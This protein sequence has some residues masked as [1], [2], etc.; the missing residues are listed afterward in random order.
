MTVRARLAVLTPVLAILLSSAVGC[1]TVGGAFGF[2]PPAYKLTEET[3]MLRAASPAPAPLPR[4]LSKAL[5]PAYIVEP[6]DTLLVL[7]ARLDSPLR[8]PGDQPVMPDGTIDLGEFGRPVVAG[9]TVAQIE[10]EVRQLVT[11]RVKDKEDANLSV[12]LVGRVSKVFYV[13]GEVNAPG[14]FPLAGRETV[15]DG[16][17]AAGGVT[18]RASTRDVIL[19]RPTHPEGCRIVLPICYDNIVQ[20]GDTSTNYQLQPGDRIFIPSKGMLEDLLPVKQRRVCPPCNAPQVPCTLG[21]QDCAVAAP[22]AG[23]GFP[24]LTS[25]TLPKSTLPAIP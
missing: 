8:L 9:K 13:L 5:L 7:P 2:T 6:G 11:A 20:L 15:L 10:A 16:I 23:T 14:A 18:R 21:S 22:V 24:I 19:S 1:S 3:K 4:E 25:T 17:I 12:R